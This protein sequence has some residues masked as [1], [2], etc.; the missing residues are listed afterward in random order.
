MS[1]TTSQSRSVLRVFTRTGRCSGLGV[2]TNPAKQQGSHTRQRRSITGSLVPPGGRIRWGCLVHHIHRCD[3]TEVTGTVGSHP[4]T[5]PGRQQPR[6]QASGPNVVQNRWLRV[7]LP[8]GFRRPPTPPES[9][10]TGAALPLQGRPR[11]RS[12]RGRRKGS[13]QQSRWGRWQKSP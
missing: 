8:A 10:T 6:L 13:D 3:R 7:S 5:S 4:R 11:S 12:R 1:Y 2:V 9:T